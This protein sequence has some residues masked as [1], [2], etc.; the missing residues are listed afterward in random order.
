VFLAAGH[1]VL[2]F[3]Q[4]NP[5]NE[6]QSYS[7][8]NGPQSD[9]PR[10]L[11]FS[12]DFLWVIDAQLLSGFKSGAGGA[13]T[14]ALCSRGSEWTLVEARNA[15]GHESLGLAQIFIETKRID[16]GMIPL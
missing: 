3:V 2:L 1:C 14:L 9:L 11:R 6:C 4:L 15:H 8:Q 5:I 13:Y 12:C 16:A 7:A 10:Q